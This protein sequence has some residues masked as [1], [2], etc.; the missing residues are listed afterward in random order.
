[1]WNITIPKGLTGSAQALHLGD[2]VFGV[3]VGIYAVKSWAFSLK[4]GQEGAL[5][6]N[7]TWTPPTSWAE[8]NR[9]S[10]VRINA[11]SLDDGVFT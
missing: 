7:T 3:E 4:P 10:S 6:F 9:T 11:V 8:S 1:M 2:R 5:L